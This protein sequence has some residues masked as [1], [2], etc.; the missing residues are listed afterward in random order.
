LSPPAE[1]QRAQGALSI[2]VARGLDRTRLRDL[3]QCG[4]LRACFPRAAG[5]AVDAVLLNT[6]G[7]IADGDQLETV[8]Q[9]GPGSVLVAASQAAERVYRAREGAAAARVRVGVT[10]GAGARIDYLPQA[11]I[12]FDGG[13]LERTL[14][15]DMAA[16]AVYVGVEMLLLGRAA[17]G[18][19]L[20]QVRLRDT[21]MLR[22]DGR[23]VLHDSVRLDG[24]V[25]AVLG[26]PATAA[27][28][29]AVASLIYAGPEAG[30]R[31]NRLRGTLEGL[32]VLYGASVR[33]GVV[34][35]G[36]GGGGGR[37]AVAAA[38]G[39]LR[40]GMALPLVWSC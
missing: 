6:S 26:G 2:A 38:L 23:L 32:G 3:R 25:D 30:A 36:G 33:E 22:R 37:R 40:D 1:H 10:V 8:L 19:V 24:R 11:T 20:R 28:A 17:S 5:C 15:I 31:L 14:R 39:V 18:E 27:G 21:V 34:V 9:A 13:A 7:G 29:R 12:L 16:D 35:A 4:C